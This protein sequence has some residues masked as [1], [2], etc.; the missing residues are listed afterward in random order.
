M[1]ETIIGASIIGFINAAKVQFPKLT[2]I[3]AIA[4]ALILG[5]AAGYFNVGGVNGVEQG[6]LIGLASSGIYTVAKRV[7]GK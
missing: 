5:V 4:V 3:Y 7:G 6:L 1:N 2:G